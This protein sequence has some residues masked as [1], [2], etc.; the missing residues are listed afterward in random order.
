MK[1]RS[2]DEQNDDEQDD[3]ITKSSLKERPSSRVA[4]IVLY[5]CLTSD[6]D[7]IF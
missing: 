5:F 6:F 3:E 2:I 7:L 4:T 1:K